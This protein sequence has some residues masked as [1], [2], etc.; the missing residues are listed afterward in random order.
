MHTLSTTPAAGT[1]PATAAGASLPARNTAMHSLFYEDL[2]IGDR[3]ESSP[4]TVTRDRIVA[5]ATEFDPQPQHLDE[6]LARTS[7]FGTLVASGWHTAS[8]TMRLQTEALFGRFPG[9]ALG[10]ALDGLHWRRP[11]HPGDSLR[12]VVEV[13]ALRLSN[14]RPAH[15]LATLRT[16]TIDQ[17][18][19]PVMDMT[20]SILVPRRPEPIT[21]T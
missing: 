14:S 11:V 17:H 12:A 1:P 15:G 5:F 20:A 3:F 4:A 21:E 8:L 18:D 6:E 10:A 16:T 9:G 19:H 13:L 7:Q 2:H